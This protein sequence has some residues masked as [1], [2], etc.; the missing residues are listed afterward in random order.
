[1]PK[2][3]T[4]IYE[5]HPVKPERKAELKK[6]GYRIVDVRFAPP[7]YVQAEDKPIEAKSPEY[8]A[9][10]RGKGRWYVM[11]GDEIISGPYAKADI[12]AAVKRE[13]AKSQ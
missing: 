2:T 6:A 5:R 9:Q 11:R 13:K 10:H 7:G 8:R 4:V 3:R 1:M 12:E